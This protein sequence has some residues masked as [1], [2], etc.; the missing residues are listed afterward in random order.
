MSGPNQTS[1]PPLP[2]DLKGPPPG[3]PGLSH[4]KHAHVLFC[5]YSWFGC[6]YMPQRERPRALG[7]GPAALSPSAFN[8]SPQGQHAPALDGL[9][10]QVVV[11][12]HADQ[13]I[14]RGLPL[15]Q[16]LHAM[17]GGTRSRRAWLRQSNGRPD[18]ISQPVLQLP[19]SHVCTCVCMHGYVCMCVCVCM[20]ECAHAGLGCAI[21]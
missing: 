1:H 2:P 8:S 10:F 3:P 9:E 5:V 13:G 18:S 15:V 20:F 16:H 14:N 6:T 7:Q 11:C 17:Q 12:T 21:P 4:T 19:S